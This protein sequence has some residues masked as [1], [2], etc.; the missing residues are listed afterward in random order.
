MNATWE[1]V[2]MAQSDKTIMIEGNHYFPLE[3]V[4]RE[5]IKESSTITHCPWK[6]EAH[7]FDVIVGD[8]T[9]TDAAWY[10]PAPKE[11]SVERVGQNFT[12]YVAFWK[13]VIVR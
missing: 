4:G 13:N 10:Y 6:G 1:G 12:N 2:V 3:S 8:Q 5:F 7:Y 9:N 11:G